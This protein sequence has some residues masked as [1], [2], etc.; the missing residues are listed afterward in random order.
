M[1]DISYHASH[2]EVLRVSED[3]AFMFTHSDL[4]AAQRGT[5]HGGDAGAQRGELVRCGLMQ[6]CVASCAGLFPGAPQSFHLH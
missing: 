5:H 2:C 1:T 4:T 6:A 3:F